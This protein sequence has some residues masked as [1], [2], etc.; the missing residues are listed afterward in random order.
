MSSTK[1]RK[2][3]CP[4]WDGDMLI[5]ENNIFSKISCLFQKQTSQY[6]RR[7]GALHIKFS[8]GISDALCHESFTAC[9]EKEVY[10]WKSS[11]KHSGLYY[12]TNVNGKFSYLQICSVFYDS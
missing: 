8:E 2:Y 5:C 4:S 9:T 11:R 12:D 1:L 3:M 7:I 6:G 10:D